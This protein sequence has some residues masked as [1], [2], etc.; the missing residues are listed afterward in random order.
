MIILSHK[1]LDFIE[2]IYATLKIVNLELSIR[3]IYVNYCPIIKQ[4]KK[5]YYE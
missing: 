2:F 5:Y 1:K 4:L 3:E